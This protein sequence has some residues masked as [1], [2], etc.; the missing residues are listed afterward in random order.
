MK[1]FNLSSWAIRHGV[2]VGFFSVMVC[3]A[4]LASYLG[5]GRSED[6]DYVIKVVNVVAQW[7]GASA[8]E[9]RDQVADPIEEKLQTIPYFDR[10]DTYATD[11]YLAMQVWV[12]D[13]TPPDQVPR[14]FYQ[15]RKKLYDMTASLPAGLQGPFV[16]DEFGDVDSI[17]LAVKGQGASYHDLEEVA[18]QLQI[19]LMRHSEISRVRIYGQQKREIHVTFNNARIGAL[20][21]APEAIMGALADFAALHTPGTLDNDRQRL[22]LFLANPQ[23]A[24]GALDA[25]RQIPIIVD[26]AVLRLGD[27]ATISAGYPDPPGQLVRHGGQPSLM[28]GVIMAKGNQL[29]RI[30]QIVTDTLARGN[31]PVGIDVVRVSDQPQV[32]KHAIWEFMKAFLEALLIVLAV[33]FVAL[34]LRTGIV[35]ALTVPIVLAITFVMMRIMGLELHRVSLGG[36]IIALGL[37]VDDAVIAIE[38]MLRG[39]EAGKSRRD[40]AAMA[41]ESVAFPMLTGTL[42]TLMGFM[43]VGFAASSTGEYMGAL[44]WVIAISLIASWVV[45]VTV[46]P[47]LGVHLLRDTGDH[48]AQSGRMARFQARMNDRLRIMVNWSVDHYGKVIAAVVVMFALAALGFV[49]VQKQFFPLSERSELFVQLRLPQGSSVQASH[50][51]A[52]EVEQFLQGDDDAASV[53]TYVG[54][55]PPRFWLALNPALPNPAYAELVVLAR[56]LPARERLK[57]KLEQGFAEGLAASARPRVIRFSFGP[58]VAYP[59][60]YRISGPDPQELRRIGQQVRAVMGEDPRILD[61]YMNWN[62]LTPALKLAVDPDRMRML[63]LTYA[64]I[65]DRVSL[66]VEGRT[67]ATLRQGDARIDIVLRAEDAQG[68]DPARLQDLIVATVDGTP[69][70]LSQLARIDVTQEEPIIWQRSR[71]MTLIVASDVIDGAQGPDV[72][73]AIWRQLQQIREDL[74]PGYLMVQGGA[75]EESMKANASIAAVFPWVFLLML[76]VI[77]VQVQSVSRLGLVLV[78]APLGMIGASLVLNLTGAPFG[79]VALLGLLALSGMD[80]RNSVILIDKVDANLA[81]G[82]PAREAIVEATLLRARPVALTAAAAV[83]AL[84]PLSRSLFWGPMALTIMGGLLL[85]T[86]MTVLFLPALYAFWF[87]KYIRAAQKLAPDPTATRLLPQVR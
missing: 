24:E 78:S 45:A 87:R 71:E 68:K 5:L 7:P 32:V 49:T 25:I 54:G 31:L 43:P 47:W 1:A 48:G 50:E 33:C 84:V 21:S 36:L 39:V 10:I 60:E 83:L 29:S 30:D 15:V 79:F 64:M 40:S 14:S 51:A 53:S 28:V 20:P 46:T 4:G 42:V 81:E 6:P 85:A 74:P 41:W 57:A 16:D 35:V 73:M 37:L 13:S 44:F 66:A 12:K 58:P 55:G 34:G 65:A 63:G 23:D 11:G 18:D 52:A 26:Q 2:L 59:V 19:D 80:I 67:A 62:E 75:W 76:A 56:D 9:M 3:V 27:L 61:A 72:S 77:M 17:L 82:F 70:P 38:S 69:I 86:F 8:Q 22:R